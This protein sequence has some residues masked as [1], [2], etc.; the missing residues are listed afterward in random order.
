MTTLEWAVCVIA[1]FVVL[2]CVA[3]VLTVDSIERERD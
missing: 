3:V 1:L 2:V